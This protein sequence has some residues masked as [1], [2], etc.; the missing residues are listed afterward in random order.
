MIWILHIF[1]TLILQHQS[2]TQADSFHKRDSGNELHEIRIYESA[3]PGTKA[4]LN[5]AFDR[6]L[7]EQKNCFAQL[8]TNNPDTDW[9]EFDP[10]LLMF[11]TTA[12]VPTSAKATQQAT[13]HLMCSS[14][15]MR[16]IPFSIHVTRRNR[17]PP[18]FSAEEY[19]FYAPANLRVGSEV[20]RVNVIDH[21]PIIYNSQIQLS[22]VRPPA[23]G[24]GMMGRGFPNP[25]LNKNE[26]SVAEIEEHWQIFKNESINVAK[27]MTDLQLYRPYTIKILAV[28]FGSP[29]LFSTVNITIVPVSVSQPHNVRVNVANN[30]YQ[31]FE[32]D[33]PSFGIAEKFRLLIKR[34][35]ETVHSQ[36][37]DSAMNIVMSRAHLAIGPEYTV[38]V[39]AVDV[40]GESPS[41]PHSFMLVNTELHCDGECSPRGGIPMCYYGQF[42]KIEQYRDMNGL[43]CLCYDGYSSAQCDTIEQCNSERSI[44]TYGG[45]DWPQTPV[46][47]SSAILCPYNSNGE[48]MKRECVWDNRLDMARWENVSNNGLCKKQ[49]SILVHLGVLANFAQRADQTVSGLRAVQ[50]FIDTVLEFPSFNPNV[51]TAHFDAKIAEHVAQ[52]VDAIGTRNLSVVAGNTT[53][54]RENLSL[55]IQQFTKRLPVPFDLRS[56]GEG[57]QM[58]TW[59]YATDSIGSSSS[60]PDDAGGSFPVQL[61]RRCHIQLPPKTKLFSQGREVQTVRVSCLKS[62]TL[63]PHLDGRSPV[64][65]VGL[66]DDTDYA[67]LSKNDK[68]DHQDRL[69]KNKLPVGTKALIGLRPEVTTSFENEQPFNYTCAYYDDKE[70]TWSTA[71]ITVLSRNFENGF[72]LCE[73]THLS[74][75]A[76]LPESMFE[77]DKYSYLQSVA[78]AFPIITAFVAVF[79]TIFLLLMTVFQKSRSTDP[80]LILFLLTMLLVHIIHLFLLIFLHMSPGVIQIWDSQIYLLLQYALISLAALMA[81][82]NS[83][84][85]A[86]IVALEL[87]S[88]RMASRIRRFIGVVLTAVVSPVCLCIVAWLMDAYIFYGITTRN[89]TLRPF[90]L[91]FVLT[92]LLPLVIFVGCATGYGCYCLYYGNNLAKQHANTSVIVMSNGSDG[93]KKVILLRDLA[94]TAGL[95]LLVLLLFYA[96]AL[97]FYQAHNVTKSLI[98][99]LLHL[100]LSFAIILFVGYLYRIES[101]FPTFSSHQSGVQPHRNS[102][103]FTALSTEE[104]GP[105]LKHQNGNGCGKPQNGSANFS[106]FLTNNGNATGNGGMKHSPGGYNKVA[107]EHGHIFEKNGA[108][109]QSQHPSMVTAAGRFANDYA[110]IGSRERNNSTVGDHILSRHSFLSYKDGPASAASLR[111]CSQPV[112]IQTSC[113]KN[114]D[115]YGI[116]SART[117]SPLTVSARNGAPEIGHYHTSA[118]QKQDTLNRLAFLHHNSK[119][120]KTNAHNHHL[121]GGQGVRTSVLESDDLLTSQSGSP[122]T[123]ATSVTANDP[124]GDL[125][126]RIS[127]QTKSFFGENPGKDRKNEPPSPSPSPMTKSLIANP[128]HAKFAAEELCSSEEEAG[129]E[130]IRETTTTF[131]S[132]LVPKADRK[133]PGISPGSETA[134]SSPMEDISHPLVSVV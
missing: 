31:I 102:A 59:H 47:Q 128:L 115:Y 40:D 39:T 113:D 73:T 32:W 133:D 42:H 114:S 85:H 52:V 93:N 116:L 68:N 49:S 126:P 121:N 80:A 15:K 131:M 74:I 98:L 92:Y 8:E 82:L 1:A 28:D 50:R 33:S 72:V 30:A 99:G 104:D 11:Q 56:S 117:Y 4:T 12:E 76:L 81:L 109:S 67:P 2:G 27:M 20:G 91:T 13:L 21:D 95:S 77:S 66:E 88:V 105:G 101:K 14:N 16:S 71:G 19:Q 90:S 61:I 65:F 54:V 38:I 51:S 111:R 119:L 112:I 124:L 10:A 122:G 134:N 62:S 127:S 78:I 35:G 53:E 57:L 123:T 125:T 86:R 103:G 7:R 36:D 63:F 94:N 64:L 100:S 45:I 44:E 5:E 132:K 25:L 41:E 43:H 118:V 18:K 96:K 29:Q 48:T 17:Y 60:I 107:E 106:T 22:I 69:V 9:I 58:R 84:I 83:G 75:F 6:L 24:V 3:P 108:L 34:Q 46:N 37:V 55:Y 97:I 23:S 26:K 87:D 70:H 130:I 89:P 110:T 120:N 79:C 129:F